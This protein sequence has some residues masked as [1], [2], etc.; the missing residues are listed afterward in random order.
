MAEDKQIVLFIFPG[1]VNRIVEEAV[2]LGRYSVRQRVKRL[3]QLFR[4]IESRQLLADIQQMS[5]DFRDCL[6]I[7]IQL[8]TH[9]L[10]EHIHQFDCRS[11]RSAGEIPDIGIDNIHSIDNSGQNRGQTI[12]GRT[13]CMKIYRNFEMLFKQT[14]HFGASSRRNQAAHIFNRDHIG[15]QSLHL[16][17]FI[18]EIFI[19]KNRLMQ[20]MSMQSCNNPLNSRVVRVDRVTDGTISRPSETFYIFD[21][22][23]YILHI[24]QRIEYAHDIQSGFY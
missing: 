14:N 10:T 21:C 2:D 1:R 22:R 7:D 23:F 16:K 15:P 20:R 6:H 3:R 9:F 8:D 17:R 5:I 13:M 18:Q 11:S 24:I 12:S 19:C 4:H